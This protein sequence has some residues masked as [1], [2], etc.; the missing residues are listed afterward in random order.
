MRV[1]Q[2]EAVKVSIALKTGKIIIQVKF[3][4]ISTAVLRV[5]D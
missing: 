2:M 5:S 4:V 1:M 3:K